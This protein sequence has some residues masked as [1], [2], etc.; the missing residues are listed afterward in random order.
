V[1]QAIN[2]NVGRF[3][4]IM[5]IGYFLTLLM[6]T[7]MI[8]LSLPASADVEESPFTSTNQAS[9]QFGD[10]FTETIIATSS[11]SLNNP[12]DLEFHPSSSRQNE[13]WVVN[14]ATDSVTIISNAG[15]PS[16]SSQNRQDYYAYH[17]MEEVSAIAFGQSHSEF[18]YIFATAQDTRNTYNGQSAPNNFMG[19]A[20]WPSS[21]S[22]FAVENQQATG[23]LGSHL[24]MLH[25]SPNG[26]GIAHDSGN[27]Y[28]YNDGYYGEL[29]YYD[30]DDDHDTGGDDHDDGVVRRYIEI[31]LTRSAGIPGHMVLDKA[32]G[33]LYISDTGTGRV[34]WVN[35]DDTTTTS[36]D[37]MGSNSQMDSVLAEYSQITNVEW[38]V[39]ATGL[40]N[41]SGI[42]LHGDTLFVSQNGNG[43]ISAYGLASNGKSATHIQTVDTNA[44][45]IMGLEVG[46]D[47][48]LWY[49]DKGTN[50][51][52]RIDPFY[53]EDGDSVS[54]VDD[55]CPLIANTDQS[56]YDSD[57]NGDLCDSDDDNDSVPDSVDSC[58]MGNLGW[59]S[60]FN[61]DRDGDGCRDSDE[62]SDDDNDLVND[63]LDGCTSGL[64]NWLSG[65]A[66]DYDGDG[67]QDDSE[68]LDDD[69][70]AIC[71]LAVSDNDCTVGWPGFDRCP[72][73]TMGW[74]SSDFSDGDHDG[75]IDNAEDTDDDDDG[76]SDL[77]DSCPLTKGT[78]TQ[79]NGI[80]CPDIDDDG[81]A[82]VEDEYPTE[83]TQWSDTDEDG[84]GDNPTGVEGDY[85][86]G[87]Y[88]TSTADLL[89][90]PDSDEDSY[91]NQGDSF[92][93]DSTQWGDT[94]GDGYGDNW[95]DPLWNSN[96]TSLGI[97]IYFLNAT[98]PD[99]CPSIAGTSMLDRY[100][101]IDTDS[102][103]WSDQ[104]DAFPT[105][106]TQW[107]DADGDGY[108]DNTFGTQADDCPDVLGNSTLDRFGCWDSDGDG[109]SDQGDAFPN[110]QNAWSDSDGDGW[111]D[112]SG[113]D[114]SDDCPSVSGAS[115]IDSNGCLDTDS[116][117]YSDSADFYPNDATLWEEKSMTTWLVIASLILIAIIS[118]LGFMN[119]RG[120]RKGSQIDP[121]SEGIPNLSQPPPLMA[122]IVP[123][124]ASYTDGQQFAP[125]P[126][127]WQAQESLGID[128]ISATGILDSSSVIQPNAQV[129]SGPIVPADGLPAGWT[130]EQWNWYGEDWLKQNNRP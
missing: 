78:S 27:A 18:D 57:V 45:S 99:S 5:R 114:I 67:C 49:V 48:K 41:P 43:K 22:H 125:G 73:G 83:P 88:G 117:G 26:I 86:P 74:T 44:N 127:E 104:G 69:N 106:M 89:G 24:D 66:T 100:G 84:Y 116:D 31:T 12:S 11:N 37:I 52:I 53:D 109:W 129:T 35:T 98:T 130:M 4:K 123:S 113:T 82:D 42:A 34:L 2:N 120:G 93:H 30:F 77:D 72:K 96:R 119:Y 17:F 38:G 54:D 79:G 25:E 68:D 85:C 19:P 28:W 118:I 23:P 102:D 32:N 59:T 7:A 3:A 126:T 14:R 92:P 55:N 112:Q 107:I 16:Q 58:A 115:N 122:P 13:L 51:V 29:V 90:C 65:L 87:Q 36:N 9:E 21:L 40:S 80:G 91:S 10:G 121:Y 75:C 60:D 76:F 1:L 128:T 124:P 33:I 81:W 95:N 110:N 56:N 50:R 15:L 62:D 103:D 94:D 64:L 101:C 61:S 71:D 111:T 39:L 70:D 6:L 108:G 20:L 8:P 97:G 105:V 63:Y 47:D 46:P